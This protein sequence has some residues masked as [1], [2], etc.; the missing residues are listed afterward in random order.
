MTYIYD[1]KVTDLSFI[2]SFHVM[3]TADSLKLEVIKYCK[4]FMFPSFFLFT[5]QVC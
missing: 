1:L 3:L 5:D 2:I 4:V